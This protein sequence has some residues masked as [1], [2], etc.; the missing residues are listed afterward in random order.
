MQDE[1][2]NRF[3]RDRFPRDTGT[4]NRDHIR[5]NKR[6]FDVPKKPR[7]SKGH[8]VVLRA[9]KEGGRETKITF[10]DGTAVIGAVLDFDKY[11]IT[12]RVKAFMTS[13]TVSPVL[14][15]RREVFFKHAIRSFF[16]EESEQ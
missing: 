12:L 8:E 4:L 11:T 10:M 3:P 13:T 5:G 7:S 15:P 1:S 2:N 16:G 9:L 14:E 6:T